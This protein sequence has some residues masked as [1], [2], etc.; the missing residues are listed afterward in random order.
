V[1]GSTIG[2]HTHKGLNLKVASNIF[3]AWLVTLPATAA[4]AAL[5]YLLLG[6]V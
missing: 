1:A 2:Q 3:L 6:I 4:M 5:I